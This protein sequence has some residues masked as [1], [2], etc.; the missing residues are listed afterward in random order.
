VP[1]RQPAI[2]RKRFLEP[3]PRLWYRAHSVPLHQART[4]IGRPARDDAGASIVALLTRQLSV[5]LRS[6]LIEAA[7]R[8]RTSSSAS[9][10]ANPSGG[11]PG[12]NAGGSAALRLLVVRVPV[13]PRVLRR[14]SSR[15]ERHPRVTPS[16]R[17]QQPWVPRLLLLRWLLRV[18]SSNAIVAELA[19]PFR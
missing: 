13:G 11:A 12:Q 4:H 16:V 6:G 1:E 18:V 15:P 3:L 5:L 17:F 14:P 19:T 9:T 7:V 2:R 10:D 8:F